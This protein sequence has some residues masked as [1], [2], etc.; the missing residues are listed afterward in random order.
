[1]AEPLI[2]TPGSTA[3]SG[4]PA[5]TPAAKDRRC[6][7]CGQY[8]TSSS[9]GRHLDLY[10][11]EKNPKPQ[12]G[13][14]NVD[15]IRRMRG[16]ITRRQARNSSAKRETSTPTAS[17][18][19]PL[20]GPP[21]PSRGRGQGEGTHPGGVGTRLNAASWHATGVI[22]DLPPTPRQNAAQMG[23]RRDNSRRASV[24]NEFVRRQTI[25]DDGETGRAV[26]LALREVLGS[27]RA[28]R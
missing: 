5:K 11:K 23:L 24:K 9:L 19:S 7:F 14:H 6:D 10:V 4:T 20:T 18:P 26:D 22:N 27:L 3:D 16:N 17:K 28:A 1:M 8:F 13:I 2:A 21:S 15:E 12:D 25:L